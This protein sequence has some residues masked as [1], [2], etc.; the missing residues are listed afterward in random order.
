MALYCII[1]SGFIGGGAMGALLYI[2]SAFSALAAP[3]SMAI[4]LALTYW[5]YVKAASRK[6]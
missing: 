2:E 1:I 6:I 3:S 4:I 5:L